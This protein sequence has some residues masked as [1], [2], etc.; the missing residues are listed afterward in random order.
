MPSAIFSELTADSV[1]GRALIERTTQSLL[2]RLGLDSG[3]FSERTDRDIHLR[4]RLI[5]QDAIHLHYFRRFCAVRILFEDV[6]ISLYV[7]S[8]AS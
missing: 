2:F 5:I 6:V 1:E 3:V 7:V 4:P 8:A